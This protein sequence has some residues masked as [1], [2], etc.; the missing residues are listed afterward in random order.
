MEVINQ[1]S[2]SFAPISGRLPFPDHSL[3]L[4]VKGTFALAPGGKA[5][6]SKKQ[7]FPTGDEHHPDNGEMS[8]STRYES[9]FA[10]FKPRSDL[11]LAGKCHTPGGDPGPA[12]QATFQVGDHSKSLAV[13]GNR[14]WKRNVLRMWTLTDPE[15]FTQMDLRYEYSFG[16]SGYDKNPIGKG[17]GK[18][19]DETGRKVR[20]APNI[21]DPQALA[22]SPRSRPEPAGFGPL[23]RTWQQRHYKMGTYKGKYLK[24]RWPWFPEDLDWT[25]FNAAPPDM[26]VEGYLRGDEALYFENLHPKHPNYH[27]QL[28]GIRVRCFVSQRAETDDSEGAFREVAMNLDTL[29]VDMEAEQLVLVW[30]GWT[31]VLSEEYEE[32]Q[33]TF[34]MSESLDQPSQS[35]EECQNLYTKGLAQYEQSWGSGP[36]EAEPV[37][38]PASLQESKSAEEL[39]GD[40]AAPSD[41]ETAEKTESKKRELRKRLEKQSSALLAQL[42]INLDNLPPEMLKKTRDQQT[43]IIDQLTDPQKSREREKQRLESQLKGDMDK[44]GVDIENLPPLSEKA[45]AEQ[46]RLLKELGLTNNLMRDPAFSRT[47]TMLAA[48]MPN[49]GIDP[50]DLTPLI[51]HSRKYMEK[52]KQYSP[53]KDPEPVPEEQ[54]VQE[55]PARLTRETVQERAARRESFAGED[56]RNLDLSELQLKDIDFSRAVFSGANLG[57]ADLGASNL[58]DA[59]LSGSDLRKCNLAGANLSGANLSKAN[60]EKA[61]LKEANVT[62]GE[63]NEA[64]LRGAE[65]TDAVFEEAKMSG[66]VLDGAQAKD[67]YFSGADLS[68]ASFKAADLNGAD[69]S[70]CILGEADF[71][72]ANLSGASVEGVVAPRSDFSEANLTALRA[73]EGCDFSHASFRKAQGSESIWH[74][75]QLMEADFSFCKME[76]ADFAKASLEGANLYAADMKYSRFRKANLRRADLIQMNLFEGSLE[77]ADLTDTDLSGSN[78]YGAEFLEAIL[79]GTRLEGANLKRT[80][81]NA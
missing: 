33:R 56:L 31:D 19:E 81:L 36:E 7:F 72:G 2:Y 75:A 44:M 66:T 6:P 26:Q 70:R 28:P 51:N 38:E 63:L 57:G 29:W 74:D 24:E 46:A 34:I 17:L 73:S 37:P 10:W 67:A 78:L 15:P 52:V 32:I 12:C 65:L 54:A 35:V 61:C 3:T 42:G 47:W 27:C 8:G 13:F 60:L 62:Q 43:R 45:K 14:Y 79:A 20:P 23:G 40:P 41:K 22:D 49:M 25:H 21:E 80:K 30:R 18:V 77:K 69:L 11:L 5:E 59:D 64:V 9:D 71:R 4:L 50:E 1:T 39:T 68:G 55:E 16:G 48:L 76:G 58:T 53:S